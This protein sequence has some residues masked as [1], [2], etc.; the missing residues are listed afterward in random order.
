[1]IYGAVIDLGEIWRTSLGTGRETAGSMEYCNKMTLRNLA[2]PDH[3]GAISAS[4]FQFL[5]VHTR[6]IV[7]LG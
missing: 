4:I 6:Q 7:T 2:P 3:A 5:V 1:M